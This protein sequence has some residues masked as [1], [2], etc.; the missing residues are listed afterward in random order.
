[1]KLVFSIL[2][3]S[4]LM[5][6]GL[7]SNVFAKDKFTKNVSKEFVI[8]SDGKVELSNQ[9]GRIDVRSTSSDKVSID[10]EFVV[11]AKNEST[12]E[13]IFERIN[14]EF[15]NNKGFVKAK[16]DISS[17][18]SWWGSSWKN[19]DMQINY[20]VNLP[21]TVK[22]DVD[23][24]YGDVYISELENDLNLE[25]DYG[26]FN[27][28]SIHDLVLQAKYSSGEIETCH[29][30]NADLAYVRDGDGLEIDECQNAIIDSKYSKVQ[31]KQAEEIKS[32]AGYD[33]YEIDAVGFFEIDGNYN[34]ITLDRVDHL[35][36]DC[37]YTSI[38][39]EDLTTSLD[40]NIGYRGIEVNNVQEGF[41]ILEVEGSYSSVRVSM[42]DG[43][44]YSVDLSANYGEID[45]DDVD[46]NISHRVKDGSASV[47]KGEKGNG[48]GKVS[49]DTRYGSIKIQ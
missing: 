48:G 25:I 14:I 7:Y 8:N 37:R 36:A 19:Y 27:V 26:T 43:A 1:M 23:N 30:L 6:G 38:E 12:A 35:K 29:N 10:I 15:E 39:V 2:A 44:S 41:E 17:N 46:I 16:T 21:R 22:L 20:S 18:K 28:G 11:H 49:I 24:K 45:I 42:A 47:I 3:I 31:I 4:S 13:D 9:Y 33:K 5:I 40:A 32:D 34:D